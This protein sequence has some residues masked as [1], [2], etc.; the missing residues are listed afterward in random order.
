MLSRLQLLL[1]LVLVLLVSVAQC[2]SLKID[3][4][5]SLLPGKS[6]SHRATLFTELCYEYVDNDYRIALHYGRD[7]YRLANQ[8]GDSAVIVKAARL[9]A[10]SYRRLEY[11]DSS[12]AVSKKVLAIAWARNEKDELV[13]LLRGMALGYLWTSKLDSAL[14]YNF[15]A[16]EVAVADSSRRWVPST[17]NNIG[18]IYYK[19]VNYDKALQYY[20]MAQRTKSRLDRPDH[21]LYYLNAS[22]CYSA[23]E[24]LDSSYLSLADA[25]EAEPTLIE[26]NDLNYLYSAGAYYYVK[27]DVDGARSLFEKCYRHARQTG[28]QRFLLDAAIRLIRIH[29]LENRKSDAMRYLT[30]IDEE[31]SKTPFN[32]SLMVLYKHVAEL[33][34]KSGNIAKHAY[35]L[36][37]YVQ[38]KDS[39]YDQQFVNNLVRI[40]NNFSSRMQSEQIASQKLSITSK[41]AIIERQSIVNLLIGI[42]T[43]LLASLS[44][45]L[46]RSY[47]RGKRINI[48]LENKV[49]LR[50][51]ALERV[52]RELRQGLEQSNILSDRKNRQ[53][54]QVVGRVNILS[55]M[56]LGDQNKENYLKEILSTTKNM[57]GTDD[58]L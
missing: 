26:R 55:R 38:L 31:L 54:Q 4:L 51:H 6:E 29:M 13:K 44:A 32:R 48:L 50:T 2:Q 5:K 8:F 45:L 49:Q 17:A 11:M 40:E 21:Y 10:L 53:L 28:N 43:A 42:I 14:L 46:F 39:I 19:L 27:K 56:A 20:R 33:Y 35:Y 16:M 58:L 24:K 52:N 37:K 41:E 23:L 7:A 3:S 1:T 22:L 47:K 57:E 15:Q 9:M 36:G 25:L 34:R 12:N 18:L 30:D